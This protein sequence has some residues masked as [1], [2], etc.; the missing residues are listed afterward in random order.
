MDRLFPRLRR[1]CLPTALLGFLLT[2]LPQ[3]PAQARLPDIYEEPSGDPGDGVLRPS[4]HDAPSL[5]T[6][7][8]RDVMSVT[9][10][11]PQPA[12]TAPTLVRKP[13]LR[14][15]PILPPPG[16]PWLLSFRL[17]RVEVTAANAGA[18]LPVQDWRGGRW[19]R[20]F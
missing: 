4:G 9:A 3:S 14:L 20:A 2:T 16:Q 1:V 11:S 17:L 5:V 18:E 19:R 15:L 6:P 13:A 7:T 8:G 12:V 10:V